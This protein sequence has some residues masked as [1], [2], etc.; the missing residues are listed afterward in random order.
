M[1]RPPRTAWT[2]GAQAVAGSILAVSVLVGAVLPGP[3]A[4]GARTRD[5]RRAA[6]LLTQFAVADGVDVARTAAACAAPAPS[7]SPQRPLEVPVTVVRVGSG[8]VVVAGVCVDGA[9]PFPFLV[10]SGSSISVVDTRLADRF[11]LA[12]AGAA[13]RAAGIACTASVSPVRIERWSLGGAALAPQ[14]VVAHSLPRL[15]ARR[16]IDGIVGSDVLSRFAAVRVDYRTSTLTLASSEGA[17]LP[18]GLVTGPTAR[19]D[20][21]LLDG[22]IRADAGIDV[23]SHDGEVA[24]FAPVRFR[25]RSA[26]PFLVDTG[27]ATTAVAASLVREDHL[28]SSPGVDHVSG[29][30]CS[31]TLHEALSGPWSVGQAAL[32]PRKVAILPADGI[33]VDGLLGSDVLISAGSVVLDYRAARLVL[34][35]G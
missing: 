10:D 23:E 34:E 14:V 24:A 12:S 21:A 6:P 16:S 31:A 25:G 20:P 13:R 30:G 9:G 15:G 28:A 1:H 19:P 3:S 2:I 33:A 22:K 17:P 11:H 32:M 8:A 4:T 27:A 18:A 29:F 7:M 5:L 26:L 35:A